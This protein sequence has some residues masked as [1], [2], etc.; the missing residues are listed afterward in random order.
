MSKIEKYTI[1]LN[2]IFSFGSS[3]VSSFISVYLFIYTKSI[4]MMCLYVIVR[5]G[6]FPMFFVFGNKFS[7]KYSFTLTYILG[8]LL[9]TCGLLYALLGAKLF[10]YNP[11]YVL[12]AAAIIGAGEG[13]YYFSANSCNQIVTSIQ[14]R[15]TFLAYNGAIGNVV[16][17]F[18]P[19][20][21][22]LLL[23]L[24][25]EEITA[26]KAM[27]IVIVLVFIFVIFVAFKI[28]LRV[29]DTNVSIRKVLSVSNDKQWRDHQLGVFYYGLRDGL[30][31][32][33][34]G[35][36]VYQAAGN[37]GL[38]SKLQ[39]LF[40]ICA[41]VA[42]FISKKM[43]NKKRINRTF[44]IGTLLKMAGTYALIFFENVS[45]AVFYGIVNALASASYDNSFNYLSANIIGR[46]PNEMTERIVAKEIVLS[47]SR[48][49]SMCVV[50]IAYKLLSEDLYLKVS[51]SI[52]CLS[53]LLTVGILTRNK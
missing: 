6:L 4:P 28:N 32:N 34:I 23:S 10:E 9:I 25:K 35:L 49:F 20:F 19:I 1:L 39:V 26:Y 44:F 15:A 5:I 7:K 37:G 14:T 13:F 29:K 50:L 2:S 43:L 52:L 48:I 31:L 45:G 16:S 33:T 22:S 21:A 8:L 51:A 18:S 11:Y 12:V 41:V 46:Y 30:G 53:S 42:Y 24:F 27:L 3:L 17:I 36:L 38:Y 40:S 47:F